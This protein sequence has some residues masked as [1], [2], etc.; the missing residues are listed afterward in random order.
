MQASTIEGGIGLSTYPDQ[1]VLRVERRTIPA[2]TGDDAL[3]EIREACDRVHAATP[4]FHAECDL[5][6]AQ[7]PSDV[8]PDAP[9]AAAI[10]SLLSHADR[11]PAP[12]GMS[13]WTD[14]ALLNGAGVTAV[15]F[16]PGNMGLAH[17]AEEYIDVDEV[18]RATDLIATLAQT[19]CS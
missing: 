19:W 5:L 4:D 16:G 11:D 3:A 12:V 14:A 17:A 7:P 9:I 1:C 8:P 2:E 15:C 6:F 13:A 10:A 18:E